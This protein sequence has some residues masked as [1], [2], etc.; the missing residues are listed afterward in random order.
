MKALCW[1]G[2][3]KVGVEDV[4]DP[5]IVNARDAIVRV[6]STCNGSG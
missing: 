6:T 4:P 5:R 1:Q 3:G 2:V